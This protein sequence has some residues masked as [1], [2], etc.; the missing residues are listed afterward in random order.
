[1]AEPG[2]EK[3]EFTFADALEEER[4]FEGALRRDHGDWQKAVDEVLHLH[5]EGEAEE[6]GGDEPA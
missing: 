3:H 1:M 2:K 5:P 6:E 4:E